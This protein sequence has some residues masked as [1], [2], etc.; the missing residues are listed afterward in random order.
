MRN[1]FRKLACF[2]GALLFSGC[3]IPHKG[4]LLAVEPATPIEQRDLHQYCDLGD[5]A[6]CVL[7]DPAENQQGPVPQFAILQGVATPD[8]AVF[9]AALPKSS[10]ISWFIYD[11]DV[12][13]LWKLH[14]SRK[15]MR[16]QGPWYI[17]RVEARELVPGRTYELIAGDKEGRLIE[18]RSFR[19][20][21]ASGRS[22]RFAVIS[23]LKGSAP[24]AAAQLLSGAVAAK[25]DL[26]LFA[27]GNIDATMKAGKLPAKRATALDH[28]FEKHIAARNGLSFARERSLV[29]VAATWSED[30]FGLLKGDRAF[31]FRDEAREV[32]EMFFPLWADETT[33][34]N[35]PGVSKWI[36]AGGQ[37]LAL[38]DDRSFRR[39]NAAPCPPLK[40]KKKSDCVSAADALTPSERF[41]YLQARWA[42]GQL[43]KAKV[44]AW[45]LSAGPWLGSAVPLGRSGTSH[46]EWINGLSPLATQQA[47]QAP[48]A[49]A[50]VEASQAGAKISLV[51]ADG[52]VLSAKE[53][54]TR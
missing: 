8:R 54:G 41:G 7:K 24:A 48:G 19:T 53:Y 33:I 27:G 4:I 32:F 1:L 16:P 39:G 49:F 26:I 46:E 10:S 44:P 11:R 15:L 37:A 3:S 25:P 14:D 23:G 50:L 51:K 47:L 45:F 22:L 18:S 30:E 28:F 29:P 34:V 52:S 35:G 36:P 5:Q 42:Y 13:R 2:G 12:G 38:L 17:Q 21:P 20:L 31:A 43:S 40:G 9:V 6:A